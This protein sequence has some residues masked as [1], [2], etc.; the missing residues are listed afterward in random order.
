MSSV[1]NSKPV[2]DVVRKLE[3]DVVIDVVAH[4]RPLQYKRQMEVLVDVDDESETDSD[5]EDEDGVK[6]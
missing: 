2:Y 1:S 5:G 3:V 4:S 6:D